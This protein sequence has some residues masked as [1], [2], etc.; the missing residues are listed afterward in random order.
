MCAFTVRE[1]PLIG[2]A[3]VQAGWQ[4]LP[5]AGDTWTPRL[6]SAGCPPSQDTS[7]GFAGGSCP[8]LAEVFSS[9]PWGLGFGED[10][11]LSP[12][13]GHALPS[14]VLGGELDVALL[15]APPPPP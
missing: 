9:A 6:R 12:E 14:R 10:L 13:Q 5:A 11:G 15:P 2:R 3:G 4:E 7:L 1:G 8:C